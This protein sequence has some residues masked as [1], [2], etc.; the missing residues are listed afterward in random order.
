ML[1]VVA[2]GAADHRIRFPTLH[3]DRANGR[4]VA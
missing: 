3:H 2:D 1:M 4:M